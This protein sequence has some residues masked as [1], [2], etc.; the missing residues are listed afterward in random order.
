M[1]RLKKTTRTTRT[2]RR[3]LAA[4]CFSHAN[5]MRATTPADVLTNCVLV[6]LQSD[7]PQR[8]TGKQFSGFGSATAVS[9]FSIES[10]L[11][12]RC[13]C[14]GCC[15]QCPNNSAP[16]PTLT[17]CKSNLI[18]TCIQSESDLSRR[19][20]RQSCIVCTDRPQFTGTWP[21]SERQLVTY[22]GVRFHSRWCCG[23]RRYACSMKSLKLFLYSARRHTTQRDLIVAPGL[24]DVI[25][26]LHVTT[27]HRSQAA[28]RRTAPSYRWQ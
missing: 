6:Q 21:C 12:G 20:R 16:L 3:T 5:S 19:S 27:G 2:Y 22:G 8:Q 26:C 28:H 10:F 17:N 15:S 11:S 18:V 24:I 4:L 1:A 25:R 7:R 14:A 23:T 13:V 9:Y